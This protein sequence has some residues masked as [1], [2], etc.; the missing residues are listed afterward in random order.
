MTLRQ[1]MEPARSIGRRG[2]AQRRLATRLLRAALAAVLLAWVGS[3]ILAQ[4]AP[5]APFRL[6]FT[7]D[8][9]TYGND[10]DVQAAIGKWTEFIGEA[11]EKGRPVVS[12]L[13]D[14]GAG[15]AD[16]FAAGRADFAALSPLE[17]LDVES[18]LQADPFVTYESNGDVEVPFVLVASA[19]VKNVAD[20]AGKRV[21]MLLPNDAPHPARLWLDV[22]L[23]EAGLP[24]LHAAFA[25]VREVKK[26][27]QA[28]LPVFFGQADVA[29]V[30]RSAFATSAEL[31]PDLGRKLHVLATS[32]PFVKILVVVARTHGAADRA[33]WMHGVLHA[34]DNPG[35]RQIF[36]VFKLD[37]FVPC[38]VQ[39]L[40]N[41]RAVVARRDAL[42]R[43]ERKGA[44]A[45][46]TRAV[47]PG[48][49]E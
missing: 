4:K 14:G 47:R 31:N 35:T 18:R 32:P 43:A 12:V 34:H 9:S 48:R 28:L 25:E 40:A 5:G 17:F 6:V 46:V 24:R 26:P 2:P 30:P 49:P 15:V 20:L 19:G 10:A 3:P 33:R 37:R 42:D 8:A 16:A 27:S 1:R 22:L 11:L 13:T 29:L 41:V 21:V 23:R 36:T 38:T 44:K 7:R 45:P 39:N